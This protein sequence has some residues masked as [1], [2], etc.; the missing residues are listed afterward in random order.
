MEISP[1]T[2]V[3]RGIP[4]AV[5]MVS[6]SPVMSV[7]SAAAEKGVVRQLMQ[8]IPAKAAAKRFCLLV[9][10]KKSFLCEDKFCYK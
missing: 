4:S 2:A 9:F 5:A 6:F 7:S 1:E 3:F 8:S 10:I